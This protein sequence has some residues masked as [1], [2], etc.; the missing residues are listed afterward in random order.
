MCQSYFLCFLICYSLN[1]STYIFLNISNTGQCFLLR[2][3]NKE[4][5]F[6]KKLWCYTLVGEYNS[7]SSIIN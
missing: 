5:K 2:K 6:L 3:M 4:G 1:Q 7:K